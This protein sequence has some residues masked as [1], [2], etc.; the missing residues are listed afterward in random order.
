MLLQVKNNGFNFA[1]HPFKDGSPVIIRSAAESDAAKLLKCL[2][3]CMA[4][5]EEITWEPN[6]FKRTEQEQKESIK[7]FLENPGEILVVAECRGDL[8]A[9][10]IFRAGKKRRLA[11]TGE[12]GVLVLRQWRGKGIGSILLEILIHWAEVNP[13]IEKINLK[14]LSSNHRAIRL[15]R[16]YGFSEE[17][18]MVREI[19]YADGTYTDL[20]LMAKF[21]R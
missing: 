8:I 13:S 1:I 11:H 19:K 4:D 12:F 3:A 5:S 7:V 10:L 16:K 9:N 18:Q 2:E 6:E 15:Y 14:V 20:L 21:V 17:G